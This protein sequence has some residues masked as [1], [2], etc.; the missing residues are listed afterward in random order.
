RLAEHLFVETDCI[1]NLA[2]KEYSVCISRY[3]P[4]SVR[5]ITCVFGE[6]RDGNIIEKGTMCKMA[7]GEMVRYLAEHAITDPRRIR[8]FDRLDYRF[9][10]RQSSDNLYVFIKNATVS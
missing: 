6:E 3:L 5:F 7:R 10:E 4:D 9:D 2:S 1:V 8:A